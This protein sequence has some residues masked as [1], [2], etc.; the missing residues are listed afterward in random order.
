MMKTLFQTEEAWSS[1]ILRVM[2]GV[3]MFPHG[4]QKLVG[5]FGGSGFTSTMGFFT[6][7]MNIPWILAFLVIIAESLGAIALLLG[8]LTRLTAFGITCIMIGAIWMVHLPYGFFMNWFGKQA[9]EGFEY[10]L[11]AIAI[12]VALM[13]TGSGKWS[14]DGAIAMKWKI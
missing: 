8:F 1:L 10:H 6:D 3:V 14:V 7:K 9:G 4:A 11:L 2:L 5:W 13:I 12:S